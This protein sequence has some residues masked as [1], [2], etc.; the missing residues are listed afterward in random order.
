MIEWLMGVLNP[1][2][3]RGW[4]KLCGHEIMQTGDMVMDGHGD[5]YSSI[6]DGMIGKPVM[7]VPYWKSFHHVIRQKELP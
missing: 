1:C 6:T 7:T 5:S 2:H 3:I 4:R